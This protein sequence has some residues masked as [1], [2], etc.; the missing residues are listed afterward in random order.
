MQD[1]EY[2]LAGGDVFL[3]NNF[4]RHIAI[5]DG[6]LRMK[7]I[8]FDPAFIWQ[9]NP[10]NYEY[11][12]PFYYAGPGSS[13]RA[14]LDQSA[15]DRV[16]GLF[17]DMEREW[18]HREKGYEL[19]L[20]AKLM[21]LLALFYRLLPADMESGELLL[22]QGTYQRIRP[23]VEYIGRH[24]DEPLDL[25][26]LAEQSAMSR[27]YFS[28][29]FKKI[30]KMGA[31]EYIEMVRINSACLLLAT[32]DMAVIDVC[33][34]CGYANLSSFNAAFKKRTGTTPSRYRLTPLPKPE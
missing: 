5:S 33:Y 23:S 16:H 31:A 12:L 20:K 3:I 7:I 11:L 8:I 13:N 25:E 4:E 6:S 21:E 15:L 28:S 17:A 19:L 26:L 27:T 29:C 1:R 18:L 32:T 30:M 2:P 14:S 9:G 22:L 10:E 34:A 24:Y